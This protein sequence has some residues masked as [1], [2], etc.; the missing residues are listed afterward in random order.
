[1][2]QKVRTGLLLAALLALVPY[3]EGQ[4][5]PPTITSTSPLPTGV[6]GSF[7]SFTFAATGGSTGLYTWAVVQGNVPPGL[8]LSSSGELSGTPTTAGNFLFIVRVSSAG[9]VTTSSSATFQLTINPPLAITTTSLPGG[10]F[11]QPYSATLQATGGRPPYFWSLAQGVLPVGL[12]LSSTGVISGT[13]SA[14]GTYNFV[15]EVSD[16][17]ERFVVASLSITISE[18]S[19]PLTITTTSLSS[20]TV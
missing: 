4:I 2:S 14:L 5:P 20:G 15:V 12:Q 9:T 8:G 1:M 16:T 11:G 18:P 19:A 13:P 6:T 17:L 10:V 3:A 7:Y